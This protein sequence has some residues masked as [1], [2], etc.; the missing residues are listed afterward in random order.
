M[1]KVICK[2]VIAETNM[3][4]GHAGLDLVIEAHAQDNKLFAKSM[5]EGGLILF[6]NSA[7]TAA[8]LYEPGGDVIG[9]L[10]LRGRKITRR[11]I[12]LIPESFGGSMDYSN[13]AKAA[14]DKFL[15]HEHEMMKEFAS[16]TVLTTA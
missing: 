6:L 4:L 5:E 12:D 14:L 13:A 8:K 3:G 15:K 2:Y 11:T 1:K 9:Y 7:R 10:N 16:K